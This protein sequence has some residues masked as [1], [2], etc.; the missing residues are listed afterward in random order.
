[1]ADWSQIRFEDA[2]CVNILELIYYHDLVMFIIL[3][4]LTL[5]VGFILFSSLS[6]FSCRLLGTSQK[7]EL[8]WTCFPIVLIAILV[9]PSIHI[10][11]IIEEVVGSYMTIKVIGHQ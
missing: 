6:Q 4:V 11:Y 2:V 8:G 7:L 3:I 5:V 10:L 9:A 1:M